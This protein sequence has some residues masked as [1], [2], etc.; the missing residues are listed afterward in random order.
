M[1]FCVLVQLRS[2]MFELGG[3]CDQFAIV[4]RKHAAYFTVNAAFITCRLHLIYSEPFPVL[5]S[6]PLVTS[7]PSSSCNTSQVSDTVRLRKWHEGLI[8]SIVACKNDTV[9]L[10]SINAVL[11]YVLKRLTRCMHRWAS[12]RTSPKI[13]RIRLQSNT[14]ATPGLQCRVH[15]ESSQ[16]HAIALQNLGSDSVRLGGMAEIE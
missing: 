10:C 11:L 8:P 15:C 6:A 1:L 14:L 7:L 3:I 12:T 4:P 16:V 2:H 5:L 13:R 9:S